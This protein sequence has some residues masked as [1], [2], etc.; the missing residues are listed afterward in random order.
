[1][2]IIS[3]IYSLYRFHHSCRDWRHNHRCLSGS[4]LQSIQVHMHSWI[5]QP[6]P[7]KWD[8]CDSAI[9]CTV[10]SAVL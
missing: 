9:Q 7:T 5:L 3:L 1:M 4:W 10:C 6:D 2:P 8:G